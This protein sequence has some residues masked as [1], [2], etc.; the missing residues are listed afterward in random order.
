VARKQRDETGK[1]GSSFRKLS[2]GKKWRVL[3]KKG[4]IMKLDDLRTI[5]G[6]REVT[7]GRNRNKKVKK[8]KIEV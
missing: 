6:G 4:S 7:G 1:K 3:I 5:T 8:R 2:K